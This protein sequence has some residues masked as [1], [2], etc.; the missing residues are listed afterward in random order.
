M[1]RNI[2]GIYQYQVSSSFYTGKERYTSGG[3]LKGNS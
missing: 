3:E 1:Y 2:N